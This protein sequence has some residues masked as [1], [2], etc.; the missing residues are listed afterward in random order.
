[1]NQDQNRV[2]HIG[3]FP[4]TYTIDVARECDQLAQITVRRCESGDEQKRSATKSSI[5]FDSKVESLRP[6]DHPEFSTAVR[7]MTLGRNPQ[8]GR[9]KSKDKAPSSSASSSSANPNR[10][11]WSSWDVWRSS[12]YGNSSDSLQSYGWHGYENYQTNWSNRRW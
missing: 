8:K 4:S 9:G 3:T 6:E 2:R 11:D 12:P 1:M 5:G 10:T 7:S